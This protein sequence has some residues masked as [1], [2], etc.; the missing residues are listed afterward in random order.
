MRALYRVL[1]LLVILFVITRCSCIMN[2]GP[3]PGAIWPKYGICLKFQNSS[4][5]NLLDVS[6][7]NHINM[8]TVYL[9]RISK[10]GCEIMLVSNKYATTFSKG[11]GITGSGK[12]TRMG[13]GLDG[14]G[15]G[16]LH[17]HGSTEIRDYEG[18]A[19]MDKCTLLLKWNTQNT[20]TDTICTT[21]VHSKTEGGS[22]WDAFDKVYYNDKLIISSYEY[23]R[24]KR[25]KDGCIII[26]K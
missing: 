23:Y 5:E 7:P 20:D 12:D 9:Y 3:T 18:R 11:F 26:V 2:S 21:F 1:V 19:N 25:E 17:Y 10:D 6:N 13:I 16:L 24:E 15:L 14:S 4:G 8:D 22:S